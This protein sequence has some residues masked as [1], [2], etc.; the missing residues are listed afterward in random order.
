[1]NEIRILHTGDWHL[2]MRQYG[3]LLREGDMYAAAQQVLQIALERRVHA[4]LI[5]GDIFDATKPPAIAVVVMQKLA[6]L[7]RE[8]GIRVLGIDGNHDACAGHWLEVCGIEPIGGKVVT[9]AADGLSLDIAG[10]DNCRPG[11]FYEQVERFKAAGVRPQ[12]LTIHQAVAELCDFPKTDYSA[13]QMSTQL[14][15]LGVK[16]VAMGD[17]H[18]YHETVIGGIRY[19]YPGSIEVTAI[20]EPATKTV[21]I[22]TWDG[23]EIRTQAVVVPTRPFYTCSFSSEADVDT[24]LARVTTAPVQPMV[25]GWYSIE[26]KDLAK[27]AEAVLASAGCMYRITPYAGELQ[28]LGQLPQ[29]YEREKGLLQLK[30]A[31]TAFFVEGSDEFQLVFQ[32]LDAPDNVKEVVQAYL[33][34]KG[35]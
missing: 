4:I 24:I 22:V 13:L 31:V 11:V 21:S 16:Y 33:K 1:M 23:A 17:I 12:I 14:Q 27:R 10:I 34:S 26:H 6:Q 25:I 9:V 8:H 29:A 32:L 7:A 3:L 18:A 28:K 2:G 35:L 15:P 19:A 30:D 20:D 5:A